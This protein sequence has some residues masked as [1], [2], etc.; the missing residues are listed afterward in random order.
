[1]SKELAELQKQLQSLSNEEREKV[2]SVFNVEIN[3]EVVSPISPLEQ[4]VWSAIEKILD[5]KLSLIT[6]R[7]SYGANK[8]SDKVKEIDKYVMGNRKVILNTQKAELIRIAL[9]S[10]TKTLEAR[11]IPITPTTL[12]NSLSL[13]HFSV[14]RKFPGYKSAGLLHCLVA[15]FR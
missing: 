4:I 14:E 10:L 9:K 15:D 8:Y 1:M 12:L 5:K 3:S 6:F 2:L 13:L 11:D 7:K